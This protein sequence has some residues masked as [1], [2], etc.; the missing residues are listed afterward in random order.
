MLE[1]GDA[2]LELLVLA[3]RDEAELAEDSRS[4]SAPR[5]LARCGRLV[6]SPGALLASSASARSRAEPLAGSAMRPA[7]SP[8]SRRSRFG[9]SRAVARGPRR[10]ATSSGM[11]GT[12]SS[13]AAAIASSAT[14]VVLRRVD[15]SLRRAYSGSRSL[16][17]ASSGAAMKIDE[18]A[19]EPMP[20]SSAN[21]KSFSV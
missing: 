3:L 16:N 19:P 14:G 9:R 11:S 1:L 8:L 12:G 18:Y 20:M 21:A 15:V 6:A 17:M 7:T 5:A 13:A 4:C 10:S 2:Q